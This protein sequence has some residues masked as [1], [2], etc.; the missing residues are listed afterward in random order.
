VEVVMS[1]S[2]RSLLAALG[3]IAVGRTAS[4]AV[5]VPPGPFP[6]L[7]PLSSGAPVRRLFPQ[8]E[9]R[10]AGYLAILPGMTNDI[11]TVDPVGFMGGNWWRTPNASYNSRVQEH[12]YTLS[13]LYANARPWNPYSGNAALLGRL[14]AAIA[15]YLNLQHADGSWSEYSIDEESKAA[16]GFGMGYLAKTLANL[17]LASVLPA[18]RGQI[19]AALQQG[20]TWFLNPA[21]PIWGPP[22]VFANQNAAGLAGSTLALQLTP[23]A[24]LAARLNNRIEHIAQNGQSPA[25]FFYEPTG[26]DINYN[27]EVMIPEIAE[28]YALTRNQTVLTMA[29]RFADWFGYTFVREPD[30]SGALTYVAMSGR[31]STSY[32]DNA[33]GDPDRTNL[34]SLFVPDIPAMGAFFTSREDRAA[35]R[36]AWTLATGPAPGL[37]EQDTSPRIIAHVSYGEAFPTNATKQ[38]A[39]QQLPYLQ[40]SDFAVQRRDTLTDQ[41]YCY[42]RRP[43]LY[44]AAF[45][46]ARPSSMV[47]SSP[48]MLWSPRAG[49]LVHSQQNDAQCWASL[50]PNGNADAHSDLDATY[51]VGGQTWNGQRV[52]PG[53]APVVVRYGLPDGRIRTVL[54]ITQ[55][56][57]TR[58]VQGTSALTEQIPLVLRLGDQVSYA[59]GTPVVYNQNTSSTTTGLVIR[60]AGVTV[61]ID[62]GIA[63]PATVTTTSVTFLRDAARRL[64]VL[65]VP[66]GGTLTTT[67]TLR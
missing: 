53:S 59:S 34:G 15:H 35:S 67:I 4:A 27:F 28:I 40:S 39:I 47:R 58:A 8:L 11:S 17:R 32:Y 55:D 38:A 13:W 22:V 31:T 37:A 24:T 62:W 5:P 26:M 52:V 10:F 64:H 20:M 12:V 19:A 57:V 16:T 33:I 36:I 44:L 51:F 43:E 2:R 23:D 7:P 1:V 14:D 66:H 42:V 60:R 63:L 41:I 30:G 46:G 54:T 50:L 9:Q 25:G 21:T 18:R 48:G 56:S 65:R 29:R 45:F 61:T 6:L 49:M 3:I